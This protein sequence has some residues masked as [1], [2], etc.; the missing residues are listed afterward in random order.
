MARK[1]NSTK[2]SRWRSIVTIWIKMVW[3]WGYPLP[4]ILNVRFSHW[5]ISFIRPGLESLVIAL[6]RCRTCHIKNTRVVYQLP[7]TL[8]DVPI[9][10]FL[11]H[12][13]FTLLITL[14]MI[15]LIKCFVHPY[16]TFY[17]LYFFHKVTFDL[18]T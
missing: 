12:L 7:K 4:M 3:F 10:W 17:L 6:T 16:L 8:Y 9:H 2:R 13:F 18:Q 14:F 1:Q 11:L 15:D 5:S